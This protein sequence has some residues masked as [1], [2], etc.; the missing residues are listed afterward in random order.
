[1]TLFSIE[2]LIIQKYED[3]RLKNSRYVKEKPQNA[4][5]AVIYTQY[6]LILVSNILMSV[7]FHDT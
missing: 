3:Y 2:S 5:T 1:M 7:H 4:A 6:T